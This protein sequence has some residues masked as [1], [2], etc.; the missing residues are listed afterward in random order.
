[1][2]YRKRNFRRRRLL[3]KRTFRPGGKRT[4]MKY[5]KSK[6]GILKIVR[7]TPEIAVSSS[8]TQA[9][10]TLF[11]PG[12]TNMLQ[13]GAPVLSVGSSNSYDIPF[14]MSFK[15][16]Q[17]INFG[18]I[19]NLC[20]RYKIA[21][22]YVRIYSNKSNAQAGAAAGMPYIQHITDHDDSSVPS[23]AT[24]RE[25]MGVKLSTFKAGSSYIGIK[26]RPR[27]A[28]EVYQSSITTGY[29]VPNKS[30]WINSTYS[31]VE[32]FSI[33]G[34]IS[35]MYLAA[36]TAGLESLKFDVAFSVLGKD[37]Q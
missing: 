32:H 7:K 16:N 3:K 2:A 26:C 37:F 33:K 1:M 5:S 29:A 15:L 10:A 27:V 19:T 36:S 12:V 9:V 13:L 6:Q 22:V 23:V 14:S 4:F 18:D 28:Q 24:L 34:V 20:D 30:V 8:A 11:D 35:N 25:K 17:L 21:G 31:G